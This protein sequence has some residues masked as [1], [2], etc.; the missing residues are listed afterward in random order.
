MPDSASRFCK[1]L[2]S[3]LAGTELSKRAWNIRPPRNPQVILNE[4]TTSW[5]SQRLLA[6]A[7]AISFAVTEAGDCLKQNASKKGETLRFQ[8]ANVF[9]SQSASGGGT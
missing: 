6:I 4:T 7:A 2:C 8:L 1:A 3:V 9:A 5:Q